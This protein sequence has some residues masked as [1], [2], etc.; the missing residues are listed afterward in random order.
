MCS[1]C[2]HSSRADIENAILNM[3]SAEGSL[4]IENIADH[5]N[6]SVD[7][8]KMHAMFHTPMVG[9]DIFESKDEEKT[10]LT[11]KMKLRE[12]DMLS[13]LNAEYLVTLKAMGRRL[14]KLAMPSTIDEEDEDKQFKFS[15]LLT[16]PMVE[17]YLGLGGEIRQNVKTLAEIER[18]INGPQDNTDG[19]LV[20]LATAIA[21]SRNSD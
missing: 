4:S 19:G 20:A 9:A 2:K 14:N 17:L 12:A 6:I 18:M 7:D 16:K 8:L 13:S 1:I 21:G 5:Y 15:K 10:S 3:S 11:R